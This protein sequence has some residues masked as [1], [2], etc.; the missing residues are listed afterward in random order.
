MEIYTGRNHN[1]AIEDTPHNGCSRRGSFREWHTLGVQSRVAG[2]VGEVEA[3]HCKGATGDERGP[4]V[5]DG[6]DEV[7]VVV[8]LAA[9]CVAALEGPRES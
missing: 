8:V 7:V 4:V 1:S 5:M 3:G 2:V 6:G 9:C